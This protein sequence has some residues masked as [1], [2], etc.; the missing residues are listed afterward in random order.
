MNRLSDFQGHPVEQLFLEVQMGQVLGASVVWQSAYSDNVTTTEKMIWTGTGDYVYPATAQQLDVV[1]DD[2]NDT[3][4][5]YI[6]GLDANWNEVSETITLTGTTSVQTVN[7]YIRVNRA[8][9]MGMVDLQGEVTGL[10][11][12]DAIFQIDSEMQK[13]SIASYSVPA[14]KTA[15]LFQGNASTDKLDGVDFK[16]QIRQFGQRFIV[17]EHFGLYQSAYEASRPFMPIPAKSDLKVVGK[18]S[19]STVPVT[20]QFGLLLLDDDQ[21]KNG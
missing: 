5:I 4:V 11:G 2:N 16:F 10:N 1:S 13:T 17:E 14:G 19:Q 9:N 20:A 7:S 15:Y 12:L 8:H 18:S 6:S 21:W 3:Q